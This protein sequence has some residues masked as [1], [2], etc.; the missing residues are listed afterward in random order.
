MSAT[1]RSARRGV[2]VTESAIDVTQ[3]SPLSEPQEES[4]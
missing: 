1:I 3:S 2:L 4:R